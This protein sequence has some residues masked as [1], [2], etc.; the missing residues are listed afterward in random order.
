MSGADVLADAK[1][2]LERRLAWIA[3]AEVKVGVVVSMQV[4]MLAGLDIMVAPGMQSH[5]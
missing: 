2:T 3:A 4:A 1:W 5:G